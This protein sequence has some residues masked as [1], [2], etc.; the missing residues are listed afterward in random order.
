MR[1][2]EEEGSGQP[3]LY[4][5][6]CGARVRPGTAFCVSCGASLTPGAQEFGP[7]NPGPTPPERPS[8]FDN[9]LAQLRRAVNR[10]REVFSGVGADDLRRLPG[11]ALGWFRDRPSVPKLVLVGAV[12]LV[13]AVLLSPLAVLI[14]ALVFGVS[15]IA[16]IIRVA[17]RRSVR[18]WGIVAV[19]SVTLMFAFDDIS[20]ALYGVGFVG[21]SRQDSGKETSNADS[22]NPDNVVT[23]DTSGDPSDYATAPSGYLP[24]PYTYPIDPYAASPPYYVVLRQQPVYDPGTPSSEGYP[25]AGLVVTVA[26][27]DTGTQAL[28]LVVN[29]FALQSENYDF[30]SI[31][32]VDSSKL[33]PDGTWLSDDAMLGM[34]NIAHTSTGEEASD[35]YYTGVGHVRVPEGHYQIMLL[36]H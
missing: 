2:S 9:L 36:R 13:L 30:V 19:A 33:A 14:C 26:V 6:S 20:D 32:L 10:L 25:L 22:L 4:C 16:L 18:E 7:T 28:A 12:V 21:A 35:A 23:E 17:Q 31:M 5:T 34:G 15:I 11:R 8:P 3:R 1:V 29:D 24:D 27:Y